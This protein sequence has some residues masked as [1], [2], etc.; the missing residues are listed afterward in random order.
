VRAYFSVLFGEIHAP[1]E[2]FSGYDK[3]CISGPQDDVL[4]TL[5]MAISIVLGS[6][7]ILARSNV[8]SFFGWFICEDKE[9]SVE[10]AIKKCLVHDDS[11]LVASENEIEVFAYI[12]LEDKIVDAELVAP[13]EI[14][15]EYIDRIISTISERRIISR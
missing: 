9:K 3:F 8:S 6:P 1:K 15:S 4:Y 12:N 2:S 14:R 7:A 11:F 13:E 10:V 5:S